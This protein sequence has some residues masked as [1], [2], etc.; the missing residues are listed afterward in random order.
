MQQ[1]CA[2]DFNLKAHGVAQFLTSAVAVAQLVSAA[3]SAFPLT[4]AA[5]IYNFSDLICSGVQFTSELMLQ[6][7]N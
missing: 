3:V 6:G 5:I 4:K 1:S 2:S 7:Q